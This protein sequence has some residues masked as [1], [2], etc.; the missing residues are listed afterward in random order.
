MTTI[1]HINLQRYKT[2]DWVPPP[3]DRAPTEVIEYYEERQKEK[4]KMEKENQNKDNENN[5]NDK[6]DG[7]ASDGNNNTQQLFFFHF[8]LKCFSLFKN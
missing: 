3:L 2:P 7:N 1:K 8:F 4:E 6:S 5:D